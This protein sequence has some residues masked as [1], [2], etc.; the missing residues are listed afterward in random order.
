MPEKIFR[1]EEEK[2]RIEQKRLEA[3]FAQSTRPTPETKS[4]ED[5]EREQ[6]ERDIH[7]TMDRLSA[8]VVP[9]LRAIQNNNAEEVPGQYV[10]DV[11]DYAFEWKNNIA[12]VNAL[13]PDYID[14]GLQSS[15]HTAIGELNEIL[16]TRVVDFR[17]QKARSWLKKW[18]MPLNIKT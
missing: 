4:A 2:K 7:S 18:H 10:R 13:S 11:F 5:R 12:R 14:A 15:Y 6:T 3:Q 8:M 17:K 9:M 16:K 1:F